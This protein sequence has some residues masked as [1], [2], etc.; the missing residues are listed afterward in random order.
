[1]KIFLPPFS[2]CPFSCITVKL[3][4]SS[5]LPSS[6]FPLLSLSSFPSPLFLPMV[7]MHSLMTHLCQLLRLRVQ[8]PYDDDEGM[9]RLEKE[10]GWCTSL[11]VRGREGCDQQDSFVNKLLP[12]PSIFPAFPCPK[13][14]QSFS[15]STSYLRLSLLHHPSLSSSSIYPSTSPISPPCI[16]CPHLLEEDLCL[17]EDVLQLNEV[18]KVTF[19]SLLVRI[20]LLHLCL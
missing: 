19:E 1:M 8:R 15:S 16:I 18:E 7:S 17:V 14:S 10:E 9:E 5:P 2:F 13:L 6:L 11:P 3:M 20:D 4:I 12:L